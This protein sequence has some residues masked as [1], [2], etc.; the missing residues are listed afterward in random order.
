MFAQIKAATVAPASTEALPVSVRRNVRSG[1]SIRRAQ[2]V[3]PENG[4]PED[5]SADGS[6]EAS[7]ASEAS[8]ASEDDDSLT[9]A[10]PAARVDAG[11]RRRH[12]V[13]ADQHR[14]LAFGQFPD[15]R[16]PG[17]ATG[18]TASPGSPLAFHPARTSQAD[19]ERAV[20]RAPQPPGRGGRPAGSR[21]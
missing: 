21:S 14:H 15:D 11:R 16:D 3:R 19:P 6:A 20:V 17:A 7:V 1:V 10:S 18:R 8:A 4:P 2:A 9:A 13:R 12:L 5:D